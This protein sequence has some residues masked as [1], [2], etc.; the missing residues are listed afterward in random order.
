MSGEYSP[1]I[2]EQQICTATT[3][4]SERHGLPNSCSDRVPHFWGGQREWPVLHLDDVSGIPFLSGI[5][6]V[7][8]YQHRARLRC[9]D[10]DLFATVTQPAPGYEE[11][12]RDRLGLGSPEH[13]FSVP[14]DGPLRVSSGCLAQPAL[15]KLVER[16]SECSGMLIE[17]YMGIDEAW[18]L[19][20]RI[21]ADSGVPV[22]VIA[23]PPAVTWIANDKALFSELVADVLGEDALVLTRTAKD[24]QTLSKHL[25]EMFQGVK[26]VAIKRTR[27]ASAMGNRL[28][29]V[30]KLE[31]LDDQAL[32]KVVEEALLSMDWPDG[33]EVL[34]CVWE[35]TDLS[36]STQWWIPPKGSRP[37]RLDGIYEQI[38]KGEEKLFVGSRPSTLPGEINDG[39]ARQS[40]AIAFGLQQL[41][42]VGRCSFDHLVVGDL[43][44]DQ[45]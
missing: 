20:A 45:Y 41:G 36:P 32:C 24:V 5:E 35:E 26:R 25:R 29:D 3:R 37:P 23:P 30:E 28:F 2:D 34:A 1:E 12:C 15:S 10:G 33:E 39:L 16:A 42:Y 31:C 13:I 7:D 9:G 8:E 43:D 38:L 19:A 11:Y 27:C 6:G 44:A 17:P 4:Y 40:S 21:S 18:D 14:A 22:Q